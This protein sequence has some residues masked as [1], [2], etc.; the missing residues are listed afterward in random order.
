[1]NRLGLPEEIAAAFAYLASADAAYT[2]G[3]NLIVD[4][5]LMAAGY[6]IPGE[7]TAE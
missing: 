2:T 1:M 7:L 6:F 5:G 3:Q 4:G